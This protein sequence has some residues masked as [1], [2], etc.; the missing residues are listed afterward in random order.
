MEAEKTPSI[1][2]S[3]TVELP[4]KKAL[5]MQSFVE[6]DCSEAD[7]NGVLDKVRKAADRQFSFGY[8]DILKKE[9]EQQE[10]LANDHATRMAA[11]DE[12][13]K[14]DWTRSAKKGDPRLGPKEQD[15]Q[16]KAFAHADECKRRIAAVKAEIAEHEAK[17]GA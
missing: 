3:Y 9:L 11:L 13:I 6:R 2:I 14:S 5:V 10:R 12:R 7:L 1:G 17:I 16:R 8:V 15:E 4:G